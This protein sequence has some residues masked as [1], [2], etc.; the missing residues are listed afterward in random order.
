MQINSIVKKANRILGMLKGTFYSRDPRLW[1]DC[2][3]LFVE[4]AVQ[5]WN[6]YLEKD[7]TKI[8]EV[9]IRAS[10]IP[11]G[12]CNLGYK[13]SFKRLNINSLK[14]R[15]VRGDL[16]EMYKVIRCLVGIEWT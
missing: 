2:Y 15:R 8:V 11:Y 9:Q 1:R 4:F 3:V 6:P 7:I 13:E 14:D 12:V 5:A 10:K 16:I